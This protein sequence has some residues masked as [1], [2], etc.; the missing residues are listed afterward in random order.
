M[1][2]KNTTTSKRL[3]PLFGCVALLLALT[4][5]S[6]AQDFSIDWWSLD[7]GG[8]TS[9][10]GTFAVSGIIGQSGVAGMSGGTFVLAGGI[11]GGGAFS[12]AAFSPVTNAAPLTVIKLQAKLNFA[13]ANQDT[14]TLTATLDLGAGFQPV[15]QPVRVNVGG[16]QVSFVLDSHGRGVTGKSTCRLSYVKRAKLWKLTAKLSQGSWQ[17]DWAPFGLV[18]ATIKKHGNLVMLPVEVDVSA[19]A[20]AGESPLLH[21]TATAG[22]SGTAK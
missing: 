8:G 12:P 21:Y 4:S 15:G 16:A 2:H 5:V 11:S 10:G 19:E 9:T 17:A 20:F 13:K 7:G 18:N 6:L 3:H 14:C 22:K 1:N